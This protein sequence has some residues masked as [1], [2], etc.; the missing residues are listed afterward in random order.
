MENCETCNIMTKP[1]LFTTN[2]PKCKVVEAKLNEKRVDYTKI[3]DVDLV[4][5]KGLEQNIA[6]APF[7]LIENKYL[8]FME[9]L[10]WLEEK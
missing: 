3:D 8:S 4:I 2:C 6:Q 1:I 9:I 7:M 10:S 5:K